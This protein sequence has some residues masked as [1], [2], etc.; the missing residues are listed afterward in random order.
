MYTQCAKTWSKSVKNGLA[1]N[2]LSPK[3]FLCLF[4]AYLTVDFVEQAYYLGILKKD[5]ICKRWG[6]LI[7]YRTRI[8]CIA[9]KVFQKSAIQYY[10]AGHRVHTKQ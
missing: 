2:F 8:D 10:I 1:I 5:V 3:T 9:G 6:T 7:I 4:F